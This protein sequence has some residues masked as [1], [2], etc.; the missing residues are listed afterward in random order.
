MLKTA[1]LNLVRGRVFDENFLMGVA[2][3]AAWVVGAGAEAASVMVFYQW[4]EF[5]QD[6]AVDRS[7]RSLGALLASRPPNRAVP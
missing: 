6:R 5:L 7:R 1:A 2:T 3:L 4:G